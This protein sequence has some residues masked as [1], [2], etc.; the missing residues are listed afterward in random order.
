M[1][2]A[3]LHGN[4]HACSSSGSAFFTVSECNGSSD[5]HLL[6]PLTASHRRRHYHLTRRHRQ[7]VAGHFR[8]SPSFHFSYCQQQH[9]LLLM[10]TKPASTVMAIDRCCQSSHAWPL[11]LFGWPSCRPCC[12]SSGSY[13][14]RL[15]ARR[16]SPAQGASLD[17]VEC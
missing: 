10:I 6:P 4:Y 8:S 3:H 2:S 9:S 16:R 11:D 17:R 12:H 14:D 15:S 7:D 5:R 13:T 1:T